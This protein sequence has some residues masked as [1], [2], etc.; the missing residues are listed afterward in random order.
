MADATCAGCGC[1]C[2][3][4]VLGPDGPE[5]TCALG[6]AWFALGERPPI[7][8]IE[9]RAVSLEEAAAAAAAILRRAR[10]PLV[11]GL[12]RTSCEAQRQAVALAEA[13]GAVI[14]PAGA[15]GFA[16]QAVGS[17]TA[18]FGEIRDRA[19][20]VVAWRADPVV[21]HP[22]LLE[23]LRV[24]SLVV[25]DATRTATAEQAD[26]F[27]ALD[28]DFEALWELRARVGGARLE[29][30]TPALDELARRL[31]DV[32]R[33]AFIH[34]WLDELTALALASLVRDLNG[35]RHAVTLGLR[36]DGN[37]RGAEDVLAWQTGFAT[38]VSFARGHPREV[39]GAATLLER[40]DVDAALVVASDPPAAVAEHLRGLPTI[41]VDARVTATARAAQVAFVT[42]A[43]GIEIPGT[44]HRMD[45]VPV[46]LRAPLAAERP[47]VEEVLAAIGGSP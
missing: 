25:V 26:A 23:R 30:G 33:V 31:L 45:G 12:G 24:E 21:T 27:I 7:A 32:R 10:A 14:D 37:A 22:R 20:L 3:D 19:E 43:D 13:L 9:D 46:P 41:V 5:R 6:D 2:D 35:D 38:P 29:G 40:G 42:A 16:Y 8:R 36:G 39:P 17:S 28:D 44:V 15:T 47:S 1:A 4:I 18:T 11:Y 34:G